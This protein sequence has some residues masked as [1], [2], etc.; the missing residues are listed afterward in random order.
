MVESLYTQL[1]NYTK[2][3]NREFYRELL[4]EKKVGEYLTNTSNM[5]EKELDSLKSLGYQ[6]NEAM[7]IIRAEYFIVKKD[8]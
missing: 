5:M 7:E 8:Q 1:E 3:F 4:K 6:E 2:K